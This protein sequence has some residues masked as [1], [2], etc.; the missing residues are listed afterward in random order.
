MEWF[1]HPSLTTWYKYCRSK[2]LWLGS[3]LATPRCGF[4][5]SASLADA[6]GRIRLRTISCLFVECQSPLLKIQHPPSLM[7]NHTPNP[8]LIRSQ[9]SGTLVSKPLTPHLFGCCW[10]LRPVVNPRPNWPTVVA[11]CIQGCVSAVFSSH[12][13]PSHTPIPES[14]TTKRC[15]R[16][17]FPNPGL[18]H[19]QGV[20]VDTTQIE[21]LWIPHSHP[22]I[23]Q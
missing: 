10:A 23:V 14:T 2:T 16:I 3:Y 20:S 18:G 17:K 9:G 15:W 12:P 4:G 13:V 19:T 7:T 21:L 8:S 11:T 22:K 5:C 1:T 6:L